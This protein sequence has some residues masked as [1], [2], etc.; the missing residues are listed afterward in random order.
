MIPM[1][2]ILVIDDDDL[3]RQFVTV[4]LERAGFMVKALSGGA[5][6][7]EILKASRVDAILTDLFMP[8]VDGIEVLLTVK[9]EAPHIPVV[10][11]TGER[12]DGMDNPCA[13]AMIRLGAAAMI[14]KPI[15][16]NEL[17]SLLGRVIGHGPYVRQI[18]EDETGTD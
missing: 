7:G 4:L 17:V 18:A 6:L 8:D 12:S 14:R 15:E 9:R 3:F 11:M 16:H 10:G 13:T 1:S 2:T 5:G